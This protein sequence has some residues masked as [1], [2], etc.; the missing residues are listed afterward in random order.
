MGRIKREV[1]I[2]DIAETADKHVVLASR[3][4]GLRILIRR[5]QAVLILRSDAKLVADLLRRLIP[6]QHF[7][8][9]V[10]AN[11]WSD[12]VVAGEAV[13]RLAVIGR[14]NPPLGVVGKVSSRNAEL[15]KVVG[16]RRVRSLGD[17]YTH[18]V[19]RAK[20]ILSQE[21]TMS[22]DVPLRNDVA[23]VLRLA[24]RV[25]RKAS[26]QFVPGDS[27]AA[28]VRRSLLAHGVRSIDPL[29]DLSVAHC[30]GRV[31]RS[32]AVAEVRKTI[33]NP[34]EISPDA[35][36]ARCGDGEVLLDCVHH[37]SEIALGNPADWVRFV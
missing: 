16:T 2:I 26:P 19:R 13:Y 7:G 32:Y 22:L 34:K 30:H 33:S 17:G 28:S 29:H 18:R 23:I 12:V 20:D 5:K 1:R 8:A 24:E 37:M 31:R 10:E 25:S 11:H 4:I 36:F 35:E 3:W 27:R 9:V 6:T 21:P 14:P 15:V